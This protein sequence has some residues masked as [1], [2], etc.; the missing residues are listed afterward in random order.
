MTAFGTATC[1]HMGEVLT[2][3]L[4]LARGSI[5]EVA[6]DLVGVPVAEPP[7]HEGRRLALALIM[8][9]APLAAPRRATLSSPTRGRPVRIGV[10]DVC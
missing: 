4:R 2:F 3:F 10:G 1:M 5:P 6:E 7:R 9:A 8:S